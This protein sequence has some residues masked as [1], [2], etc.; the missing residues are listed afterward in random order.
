MEDKAHTEAIENLLPPSHGLTSEEAKKLLQQYGP[1]ELVEKV[2][3]S[4][5]IF[6]QQLYGAMPMAL[7][8]A[9]A[10]RP[11][12]SCF[13]NLVRKIKVFISLIINPN[14]PSLQTDKLTNT[15]GHVKSHLCCSKHQIMPVFRFPQETPGRT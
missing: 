8:I 7:W 5:L 9:S 12:R 14:L 3:P 13:V 2:T 15:E 1:N 6:L 4:W 10:R 11:R